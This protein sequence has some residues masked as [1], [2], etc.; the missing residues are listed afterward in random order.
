MSVSSA[1]GI[2]A[3]LETARARRPAGGPLGIG[4]PL[5]ITWKRRKNYHAAL[6]YSNEGHASKP[7]CPHRGDPI[8]PAGVCQ[9]GQSGFSDFN[10]ILE[11]DHMPAA[12]WCQPE[13]GLAA[14]WVASAARWT[15]LLIN[16]VIFDSGAEEFPVNFIVEPHCLLEP[17]TYDAEPREE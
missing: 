3:P 16:L 7:D 12:L 9:T 4:L 5:R 13:I 2:P 11:H 14:R 1:D 6:K 10:I 17:A 8:I 15:V